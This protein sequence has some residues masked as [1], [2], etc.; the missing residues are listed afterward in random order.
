VV[1]SELN[2]GIPDIELPWS[3]GGTV[4]PSCFVGH[5]LVVLFLPDDAEQRTAELAAYEKLAN[6][7]AGTDAWFLTVA[8]SDAPARS[9]RQSIPVAVDRDGG[10]WR[11]FAKLAEPATE[12]NRDKGAAFLFS[13]G[14]AFRQAWPGQGH[15]REVMDELLSRV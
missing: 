14:G 2:F 9:D 8:T 13:R 5:Q 10:A 4:N 7:F 15:A 12:L 1:D 11:A 3:C 6:E